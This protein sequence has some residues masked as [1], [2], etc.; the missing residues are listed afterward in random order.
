MA[1]LLYVILT[2]N[3]RLRGDRAGSS[4]AEVR[5]GGV[6]VPAAAVVFTSRPKTFYPPCPRPVRDAGTNHSHKRDAHARNRAAMCAH[7]RAR[8]GLLPGAPVPGAPARAAIC[9]AGRAPAGRP[10]EGRLARPRRGGAARAHPRPTHAPRTPPRTPLRRPTPG[11][12]WATPRCHC[13][14]S[15]WG[16]T[17]YRHTIDIL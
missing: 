1:F 13:S 5:C 15:C 12:Q 6:G 16:C 11:A 9:C 17:C 3:T 2:R 7:A 14:T 10:N 8:S 4:A